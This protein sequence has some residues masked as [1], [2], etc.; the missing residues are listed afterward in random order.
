LKSAL[1][2]LRAQELLVLWVGA[3][4]INQKDLLERGLQVMRMGLVY[5]RAV[6]VVVWV[7]EE[8]DHS[9]IAMSEIGSIRSKKH[10]ESVDSE[11]TLFG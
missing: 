6:E 5:S 7:G 4:C 3:L 8:A 11:S 1:K 9:A 10:P 2:E